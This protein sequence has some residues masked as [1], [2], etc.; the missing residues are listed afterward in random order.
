MV[1]SW[2]LSLINPIYRC[3]VKIT[4]DVNPIYV[5]IERSFSDDSKNVSFVDMGLV[6]AV[7][8]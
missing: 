3:S 8:R 5:G 4:P 2:Y 1:V 6:Y 7:L